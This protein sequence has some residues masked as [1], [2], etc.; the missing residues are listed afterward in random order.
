MSTNPKSQLQSSG[1]DFTPTIHHDTYDYIKPQQFDLKNRAVFITGASKGIGRAT[2]ISYAKAGASQIAIAARTDMKEVEAEMMAAA[3]DAGK[4]APQ[5]LRL[6]VDVTDDRSVQDAAKQIEQTFGRLDV[7]IN[8]AGYLEKFV[9]LHESEIDEWWKVW[10]VNIKGVYLITRAL[11]PLLLKSKDSLRTILNVSSIGA[12][13]IMPGAS[14]YQ[15]GKLALLRFGEFLN[16]DYADQGILA[17]GIHPGGIATELAKGMPEAMHSMLTD[18]EEL[19]GDSIVWLTAERR[20]WIKG[21]YVSCNW[22][23]KEFLAKRAAIEDGD[24]LKV[25]L[26][27]GLS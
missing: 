9:P 11:L 17:F 13:I 21:R 10:E 6:Q 4:S 25:R 24:L 5:V 3:K 12:N 22:D 16:A 20:E 23:M 27:V 19:A 15:A 1:V 26:D 18:T 2:A 14:G 7:L 8:N